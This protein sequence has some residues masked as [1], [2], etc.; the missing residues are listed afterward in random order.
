MHLL[1]A[2]AQ[3]PRS[4]YLSPALLHTATRCRET[5]CPQARQKG[6]AVPPSALASG[7]GH[8]KL[9]R[10]DTRVAGLHSPQ[11]AQSSSAAA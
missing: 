10:G 8:A 6:A 9:S 2:G 3:G 5:I 4:V 11:E 1:S 7:D